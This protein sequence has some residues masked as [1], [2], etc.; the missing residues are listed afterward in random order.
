MSSGIKRVWPAFLVGAVFVTIAVLE[1]RQPLRRRRESRL[2]RLARNGIIGALS[3]AVVS[4][5]DR[6]VVTPVARLVARRRW[7]VL[8]C[9]ALPPVLRIA[10]G[11]VLLDYTLYLWHVLLHRVPLLWRFHIVH[12][13]DRDLDV[14]TAIRFHFGELLL[15]VPWRVAQVAILGIDPPTLSAWQTTLFVSVLF[16]HSNV[17]LPSTAE[18]TISRIIVTPRVHGIHHSIVSK[19]MNSNWSSGLMLWDVLHRTRVDVSQRE[20][21]IGVSGY[22]NAGDDTVGRMLLLPAA[23]DL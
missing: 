13:I 1:W 20:I 16:H 18:R 2:V 10:C 3:T 11:L 19:E 22:Q 21:A 23:I 8:H 6:P 17:S 12:H 4:V 7:G 14:F 9:V 15:S 5:A